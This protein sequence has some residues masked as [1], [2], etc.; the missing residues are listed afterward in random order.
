MKTLFK[1]LLVLV[2]ILLSTTLVTNL[3][4]ENPAYADSS[5]CRP[6]LGLQSW[7]CGLGNDDPSRW[8]G[9]EKIINNIW[10]IVANISNDLV[11]IAAYLVL[12]YVIYGGYLY[13][14]ASGDPTKTANGK[15]TLTRAFIGL[16]IVMTAKIIVNTLHIVLIGQAGVFQEDCISGCVDA[17]SLVTNIIN[18]VISISGLVAAVFVVV[19][20]IGYLTSSGDS[21]K[22][23]KAKNTIIY[24]LIG[25]AIVGLA[26]II[27][28]IVSSTIRDNTSYSNSTLIAKEI[29]YEKK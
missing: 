11:V 10:I 4:A 17:N 15:K 24:A 9:D 26:E 19:G 20:A 1:K 12:G 14:F 23:Q 18:W 22:L 13:M 5:D 2:A 7:D 27:T 8:Q 25:L 21:N 3:T 29:K 6:I 28:S 16:A